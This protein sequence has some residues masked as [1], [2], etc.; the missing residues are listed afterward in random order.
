M[1]PPIG[2]NTGSKPSTL[3]DYLD[4]QK[5]T[6]SSAQNMYVAKRTQFT[7]YVPPP[8]MVAPSA[9]NMM[10]HIPSTTIGDHGSVAMPSRPESEKPEQPDVPI[11]MPAKP[12][13]PS[14]LKPNVAPSSG[15]PTLKDYLDAMKESKASAKDV[16]AV[17]THP[18]QVQHVPHQA[19]A[20]QV[21]QQGQQVPQQAQQVPQQAQQVPQ[22]AQQVP[23]QAQQ[24]T[25]K[26]YLDA[27][28]ESKASAK[29]IYKVMNLSDP[30][31]Q[32]SASQS[33]GLQSAGNTTIPA[34]TSVSEPS[35][36]ELPDLEQVS[37]TVSTVG[38]P[39]NP[40]Q[41]QQLPQQAQQMPQQAQQMPQQAQQMPQQAHQAQPPQQVP[42]PGRQLPQQQ[43]TQQ[44]QNMMP[45]SSM[46]R[47]PYYQTPFH[48]PTGQY[49]GYPVPQ[50]P[51]PAATWN[52]QQP[53]TFPT[54]IPTTSPQHSYSSQPRATP[55]P[56]AIQAPFS[57]S[58]G[59]AVQTTLSNVWPV[60][61]NSPQP[62]TNFAPQMSR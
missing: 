29:D 41:A 55:P 26:D 57:T 7:P 52:S 37:P 16:Y 15:K 49:M 60:A 46:V 23:Q 4:A 36:P 45:V 44:M 18:Q 61:Q 53:P 34:E 31:Q 9:P 48:A 58:S 24:P 40:Q 35:E 19:Q 17:M 28:K 10:H 1:P 21:P 2:L 11:A 43:P 27:M 38:I 47:H 30:N 5:S 42:N 62:M 54:S 51:N 22:Q 50:I 32:S 39:G 8:I 13:I 33:T 12:S 25:L 6:N 56:T 14:P 59:S 20:Q 3:K